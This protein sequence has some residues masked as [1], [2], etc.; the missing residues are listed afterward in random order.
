[1]RPRRSWGA[2]VVLLLAGGGTA[3]SPLLSAEAAS[4][5]CAPGTGVTVVVDYGPLG[6]GTE[7]GCDP[8]GAGDPA[9]RVVPAAGFPLTYSSGE[10][11]VCRIKGLPGPADESCGRTPPPDAYWGLFWSDGE[12]GDWSYA[13][14]GVTGLEVPEGG[15]VGWRFQDGGDRENPG[16]APTVG[17]PEPTTRPTPK[18]KPRPT[19]RPTAQPARPPSSAPVT[20][21]AA[22]EPSPRQSSPAR[23]GPAR[24]RDKVSG[25]SKAA[26]DRG[27]QKNTAKKRGAA[28]Q[29]A[30]PGPSLSPAPVTT[31]ALSPRSDVD[32]TGPTS[33]NGS[34]ALVAG[35]A[36]LL[37]AGAAGVV[38]WR[39]RS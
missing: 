13:S 11:F 10:P 26:E 16:V 3:A 8:N 39:R 29:G 30:S 20:P 25:G 12:S 34:L 36:M 1:M 6:G 23:R 4:G 9:S 14:V 32:A 5:R 28:A 18:P 37:L 35:G 22:P 2:A 31:E 7:I 19:D 17:K 38:G 27:P 15:S 21:T 24:D 33:A